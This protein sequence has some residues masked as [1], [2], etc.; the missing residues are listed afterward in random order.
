MQAQVVRL[1][2]I[3]SLALS[4]PA[5]AAPSREVLLAKIAHATILIESDNGHQ[6]S[7][8]VTRIMGKKYLLTAHHVVEGAKRIRLVSLGDKSTGTTTNAQ[9]WHRLYDIAVYPLPRKM[10]HLPEIRLSPRVLPAG[11]KVAVAAFPGGEPT[12]TVGVIREYRSPGDTTVPSEVAF[13]ADVDKGASGGMIIDSKANLI[14]IVTA[15]EVMRTSSGY[16]AKG[17]SIGTP[18]ILIRKLIERQV[19]EGWRPM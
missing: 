5:S 18:A 8:V 7:G 2:L 19:S 12:F 16:K 3:I 10:Q 6:G 4:V 13:T 15:Y 17:D 11:E 14:G 9:G 1:C